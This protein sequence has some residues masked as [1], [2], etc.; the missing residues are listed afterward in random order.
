MANKKLLNELIN[1]ISDESNEFDIRFGN[2]SI[3]GIG[4]RLVGID[5]C[6]PWEFAKAFELEKN[7][8]QALE[9]GDFDKINKK[10]SSKAM[11]VYLTGV[12]IEKLPPFREESIRVLR[13]LFHTA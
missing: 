9:W 8:V 11:V 10:F 7:I 6:Y 5:N 3:I 1:F 12:P 4:N 13:Y 2:T